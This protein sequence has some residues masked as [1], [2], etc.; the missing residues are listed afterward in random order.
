MKKTDYEW[1]LIL[2]A[3]ESLGVSRQARAKWRQRQS[4]PHRWRPS[5][6]TVTCGVINWA[7]F[8]ALDERKAA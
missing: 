1:D 7:H 2:R 3:A 5:I 8:T 4:V 6:V